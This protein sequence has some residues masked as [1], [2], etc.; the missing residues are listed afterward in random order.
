[1]KAIFE[2]IR[3]HEGHEEM[4]A[5]ETQRLRGTEKPGV[6]FLTPIAANFCDHNGETTAT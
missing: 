4:R 1:M 2:G 6:R 5:A 3:G